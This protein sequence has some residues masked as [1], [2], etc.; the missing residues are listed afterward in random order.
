MCAALS[1][2]SQE[3]LLAKGVLWS[4]SFTLTICMTDR[5]TCLIVV[6]QGATAFAR[7]W[8]GQ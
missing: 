2:Q 1:Q 7:L 8:N 6:L 3:L 4:Q 5:N